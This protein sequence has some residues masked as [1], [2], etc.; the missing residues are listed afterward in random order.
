M[1][2]IGFG[3]RMRR[4]RIQNAWTQAELGEKVD[5]SGPTIS[6]WETE[7]TVPTKDQKDRIR[8]ILGIEYGAKTTTPAQGTSD[9]STPGGA[10]VEAP[11]AF[12]T[13]LSRTRLEKRMSVAELAKSSGVSG[14]AIY[15]I[16]SG[17][18]GNPRAET[19]RRL[20]KALGQDLPAETKEE[21]R[22]ESTIEGMGEFVDFDPHDADDRPTASGVYVLYDIS[23]RPVYVGEGANIRK[24]IKD[25]EEKFW[26][27]QPIV[28]TAA[29][30]KIDEEAL[31]RKVETVLIRFLKSNA[32]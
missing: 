18:I 1:A 27:K 25:H 29:F 15:N 4:G 19:V 9:A 14:P 30:V 5:V 11:S 16:E 23:E 28:E 21:L 13:W 10:A 12:G 20:E 3:E 2:N 17:R 7:K 31:R 32:V 6:N 8:G 26:F 24:R 22:E